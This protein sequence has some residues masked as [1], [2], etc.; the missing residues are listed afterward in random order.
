MNYR[1]FD[2]AMQRSG[3]EYNIG[4]T[5]AAIQIETEPGKNDI[6]QK[7]IEPA[8]GKDET[9]INSSPGKF[10]VIQ[11]D[12]RVYKIPVEQREDLES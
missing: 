6:A 5:D 3:V 7:N 10:S 12:I 4:G 8:L 1:K 11:T 2:K 9:C